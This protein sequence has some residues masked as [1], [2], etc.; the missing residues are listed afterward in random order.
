MENKPMESSL[1]HGK[2]VR[3]SAANPETDSEAIAAWSRDPE[4]LRMFDTRPARH[5]TPRGMTEVTLQL[6]GENDQVNEY[7]FAIRRLADDKLLGI[8]S[9]D[10]ESWPRRD[11]WVAIAIGERANWSQGYGSDAMQLLLRFAFAELNLA[12][13]SLVVFGYN[14]RA[15]RSYLKVGFKEE[16]RQRERIRRDNH[17]Y[18]MVFMSVLRDEWLENSKT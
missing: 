16:G 10:V 15:Q 6:Q 17:R 13:V 11:A 3:L 12:R 7:P 2:M 8:A 9:L 5:W 4:L 1:L 14:E 18:D